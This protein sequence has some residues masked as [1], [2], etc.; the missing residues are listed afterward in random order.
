MPAQRMKIRILDIDLDF[1]LNR[2]ANNVTTSTTRLDEQNYQPWEQD[3]V[4]EFLEGSCGLKIDQPIPGRI[5]T[6]HDEVFYFLRDLQSKN[7]NS[8]KFVI[9]HVDAHAD[10]GQGDASFR[11]ISTEVLFKPVSDRQNIGKFNGY[12]GLSPGNYLVFAIACR[13][14]VSLNYINRKEWS[15]DL[16]KFHFRDCNPSSGLIE[17]KKYTEEILK[18]MMGRGPIHEVAHRFPPIELEPSVPFR[19]ID[20]SDFTSDGNYDYIFLTQSPGFTPLSSDSLIPLIAQYIEHDFIDTGSLVDFFNEEDEPGLN[21]LHIS[22]AWHEMGHLTG[23]LI[24]D[25]I[26]YNFGTV[27]SMDLSTNAKI[28]IISQYSPLGRV[29]ECMDKYGF[30]NMCFDDE[31]DIERITEL[32]KDKRM[33]LSYISYLIM[34]GLFN[35]YAIKQD[36]DSSDFEDCFTDSVELYV[37]DDFTARA[38]NDWSKVRRL[39]QIEFWDIEQLKKFRTKL[40]IL[41]KSRVFSLI[42][43]VIKQIDD[44]YNGT[45]LEGESLEDIIKKTRNVLDDLTDDFWVELT[46]LIEDFETRL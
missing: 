20:I 40:F 25:R 24:A 33:T 8:L 23:H 9:D 11:Y 35:I 5:F 39:A 32:V 13:W 29:L 31:Q 16:F 28:S 15:D 27:T 37:P 34:G 45:K 10:L 22:I 41:L 6:H 30:K 7:D 26:G 21:K 46:A 1:F 42:D 3:K 12:E 19:T 18:D 44:Q 2:K 14:V 17:L 36:P 43:P 38:G 4:I